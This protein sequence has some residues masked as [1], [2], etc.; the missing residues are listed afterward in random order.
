[1]RNSMPLL[2][3]RVWAQFYYQPDEYE[4]GTAA[5][6]QLWGLFDLPRS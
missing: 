5:V 3:A 1:M 2:P 4:E 6:P